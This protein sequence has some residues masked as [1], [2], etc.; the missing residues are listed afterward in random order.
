MISFDIAM[1]EFALMP[2]P[3]VGQDRGRKVRITEFE[4][5]LALLSFPI[6]NY[7][8]GSI[9]L[10]VLVKGTGG[11]GERWSWAKKYTSSPYS[12]WLIPLTIW[13]NEIVGIYYP[14]RHGRSH[15]RG[16]VMSNFTNT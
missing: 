2:M 13:R 5:R 12:G 1:E 16:I 11:S 10:W 9:E 3:S 6:P 15:L 14:N 8:S 4:R 7:K